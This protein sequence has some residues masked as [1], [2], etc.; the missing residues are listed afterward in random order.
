MVQDAP[1]ADI[2]VCVLC[3]GLQRKDRVFVT[4]KVKD[5]KDAD[6]RLFAEGR[7]SF[8]GT[9]G[10]KNFALELDL[11]GKIKPD[12]SIINVQP[13]AIA[14][15]LL[16]D[17]VGDHWPRLP[18]DTSKNN[19][20]G[21]DHSL[22]IDQDDEEE[23]QQQKDLQRLKDELDSVGKKSEEEEAEDEIAAMMTQAYQVMLYAVVTC[24]WL[25]VLLGGAV[26]YLSGGDSWSTVGEIALFL[27]L[28]GWVRPYLQLAADAAHAPSVDSGDLPCNS[29]LLAVL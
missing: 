21:L 19:R 9:A 25:F 24:G 2:R 14:I 15:T 18:K 7:L 27:Q 29:L 22:Y 13:S 11:F 17:E 8:K 28:G 12:D 10:E 5:C 23:Q 4:I 1:G 20:I 26:T 6:V 3:A 16:R